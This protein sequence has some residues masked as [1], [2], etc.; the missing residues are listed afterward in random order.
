M[1]AT[2]TATA[3][4]S[5]VCAWACGCGSTG[6]TPSPVRRRRTTHEKELAEVRETAKRES[7]TLSRGASTTHEGGV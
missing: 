7:G 5:A 6:P 1:Q 3:N 2:S 4:D